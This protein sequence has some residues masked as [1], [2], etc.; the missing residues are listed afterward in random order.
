VNL[1]LREER[2]ELYDE[3]Y[4]P[5]PAIEWFTSKLIGP[6]D[7]I[8]SILNL[9]ISEETVI[10][11]ARTVTKLIVTFDP[12]AVTVY[13][14]WDYGEAWYAI[15]ETTPEQSAYRFFSK[16][17]GNF[18]IDNV[19]EDDRY[20]IRIVSVNVFGQKEEW[21]DSAY[22][23]RVVL[24]KTAQPSDLRGLYAQVNGDSVT[25]YATPVNDADIDGYETRLGSSWGGAIFIS[26]NK[27]PTVKLV[28]V[29]PGT[30][31]FWMS[32][33]DTSGNY[34]ANPAGCTVTV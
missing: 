9:S 23:S 7:P 18:T 27:S 22:E 19:K 20:H 31:T 17:E 1:L 32:P 16:V 24:G 29:R 5:P 28:G 33:K 11:R 30:H 10:I 8:P 4:N 21:D 13:P 14:F 34:S 3:T 25:L 26:Y 12:P 15:S 2:T 6:T